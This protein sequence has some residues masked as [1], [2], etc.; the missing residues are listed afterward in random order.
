MTDT[1]R[2][3]LSLLERWGVKLPEDFDDD[4]PLISS[5]AIDSLTL[6]NLLLWIEE[7]TGHAVDPSSVDLSASWDS[8][9]LILNY[10]NDSD[11]AGL[12]AVVAPR[13]AGAVRPPPGIRIVRYAAQHKAAVAELQTGLW[14]TDAASNRAYLE[15]KY[16]QNPYGSEPNIYLA[17][18]RGE[19]V[20]MRGLYASR[21]E[22]GL[23]AR[24]VDVLIADDFFLRPDH[25]N[26]G[27][28]T[29]IMRGAFDELRGKGG[30]Y[31]FNLTGGFLTL[32][33]SLAMG[34][35]SAGQLDEARRLT[36]PRM[37]RMAVR[38]GLQKVPFLRRY[39]DHVFPVPGFESGVFTNVDRCPCPVRTT[40]GV[41][42]QI[43]AQPR[44]REMA[45]LIV[46]L[47]YD[48]RIRHVRD[49]T[50]FDWRYRE[51]LHEYR[52]FFA[53]GDALQ[54]YL[55]VQHTTH[56]AGARG[57]VS[58]VDLEA[59]SPEVRSAL[60]ETVVRTGC[61]EDVMTWTATLDPGSINDLTRF[62]FKPIDRK[63]LRH[64]VKHV[65][66][67]PIDDADLQHDWLLGDVKLLDLG[68]WDLRMIY[69]MVD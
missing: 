40:S 21:W 53:E 35:R 42:V 22:V 62:G 32:L 50:Y 37:A 67:R 28:A 59:T 66:V 46:R 63:P 38:H 14:S 41:T 5:G 34:W 48:G 17:L 31:A 27:L 6:F 20:G 13:A 29:G 1:R 4:T 23:P 45:E 55:V 25:R 8:V 52:F 65:L 58:I 12:A 47:G 3:L 56:L 24:E 64:P 44:S 33:G 43:E 9:R 26:E 68:N 36:I 57:R 2:E 15:W 69:A 60:V 7:K 39:A 19:I 30:A 61:F 49:E 11:A 54:G 51:P 10:M 16:E 18:D